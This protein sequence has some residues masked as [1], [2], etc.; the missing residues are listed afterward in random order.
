MEINPS[1]NNSSI[2]ALTKRGTPF[3]RE[4]A[5][6]PQ[7]DDLDALDRDR[8]LNWKRGANS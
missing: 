2:Y 3:S 6:L 5:R 1:F 8:R 4:R 7:R